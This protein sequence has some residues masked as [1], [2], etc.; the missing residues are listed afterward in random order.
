MTHSQANQID[1]Q[2]DVGDAFV[3]VKVE[4]DGKGFDVEDLDEVQGMGLKVIKER[5]EMARGNFEIDSQI[6]DGTQVVFKVPDSLTG[7]SD[8]SLA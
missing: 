6:G 8:S 7:V 3:L 2:I 1:V 5:V 4:D